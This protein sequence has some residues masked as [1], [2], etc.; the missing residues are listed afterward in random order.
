[1]RGVG[2]PAGVR[3]HGRVSRVSAWARERMSYGRS[4]SIVLRIYRLLAI[5]PPAWVQLYASEREASPSP[6]YP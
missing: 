2:V 4:L 6:S 3:A 5:F 1:M